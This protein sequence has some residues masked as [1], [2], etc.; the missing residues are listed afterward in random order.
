MRKR[1]EG[2]R[3]AEPASEPLDQQETLHRPIAK[4][5]PNPKV[6]VKVK[7]LTKASKREGN[8]Q[9]VSENERRKRLKPET[10]KPPDTA[11]DNILTGLFGSYASDSDS[12]Q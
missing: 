9:T 5:K 3:E 2:N 11:A 1:A 12:G 7:A 6:M 4:V 10:L 8:D